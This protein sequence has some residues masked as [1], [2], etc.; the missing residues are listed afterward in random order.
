MGSLAAVLIVLCAWSVVALRQF[1]RISGSMAGLTMCTVCGA[2]L[3][4]CLLA[5]VSL[6]APALA[7]TALA[8]GPAILWSFGYLR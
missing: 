4:G 3:I 8:F 1:D 7:L 5:G 6:V 2:G